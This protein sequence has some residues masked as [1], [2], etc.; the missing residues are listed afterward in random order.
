M[1]FGYQ[2]LGFGSGGAKLPCLSPQQVEQKPHLVIIKF[3]LLQDL[4][5]FAYLAT[6]D[7]FWFKYR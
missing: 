2:V 7:P 4:E 6:G 5:H 1:S 3:I